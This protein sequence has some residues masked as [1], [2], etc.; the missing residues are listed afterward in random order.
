MKRSIFIICIAVCSCLCI[1]A[2]TKWD[3]RRCVEYALANNISVKQADI[4]ARI[5]E[6]T[7]KQ[8]RLQ[9]YPNL[10]LTNNT[11]ISSGRSIDP[12]TNQFTTQQ[13]V[14]SQFNLSSSVTVFNWFNLRNTVDGNKFSAEA[15]KADVDKLKNDIALNVATA[16]LLVLV[17]EEQANITKVAIQQ[18]QLNLDNTRKRVM[19]GALP[20]LNAAELEAQLARDSS[21]YITAQTTVQ[22]NLLQLKALLNLDASEPFDVEKPP[23]DEIPVESLASL[24]PETVYALALVNLPQQKINNLRIKAAQKYAEASKAQMYPSISAFAGMGTNYANNKIPEVRQTFNGYNTTVVTGTPRTVIGPDTFYLQTPVFNTSIRTYTNPFGLQFSD[25]LR[26]Q[27][28]IS[29]SVPIFNNGVAKTNWQRNKLTVK[30]LE[31]QK[32]LGDRTLKQDI[33]RSYTDAVAAVQKFNAAKKSVETAEKA[34][35]FAQK[36]YDVG[37]LP[38]IDFLTN[39]NNLTRA[40]VEMAQAHVDYVFRLKLL[41]FYRGQGIKLQ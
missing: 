25:N 12:T 28:G 40:R 29:I 18:T 1:N 9:Q 21:A 7:L 11:G 35:N 2:Q 16:Y 36:R 34:Y 14:F 8:S 5:A 19:A 4:Q 6:L 37:L 41:E 17:S 38:T 13:L 32:E 31:L 15:S 3:L 24:Q 27:V 22:Q 26:E 30:N 20:E 10:N 39:Q 23:L 33:Y